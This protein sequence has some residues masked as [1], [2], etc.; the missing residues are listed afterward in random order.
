MNQKRGEPARAMTRVF[1][2][3]N[4]RCIIWCQKY[5]F[6][7][8]KWQVKKGATWC[9]QITARFWAGWEAVVCV[10]AST[11]PSRHRH[12]QKAGTG[13]SKKQAQ[14]QAKASTSQHIKTANAQSPPFWPQLNTTVIMFIRLDN[15]STTCYRAQPHGCGYMHKSRFIDK[16]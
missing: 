16:V 12:K 10:C 8:K 4:F 9:Y 7:F 5:I 13:T 6:S 1:F 14:A 15:K 11:S 3:P 2:C